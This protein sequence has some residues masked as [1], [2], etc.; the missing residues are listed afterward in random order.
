LTLRLLVAVNA[1]IERAL[2]RLLALLFG[3][4]ILT[5]AWQVV[6]REVLRVPAIWTQ[7]AALFLFA[8]CVFLGSAVAVRRSAHYVC[9]VLPPSMPRGRACL[10]L[11][12]DAGI[13][14]AASVLLWGGWGFAEIGLFRDLETLG[15]AEAWQMAAMPVGAALMLLFLIEV[16]GRDIAALRAAFAA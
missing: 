11:L 8:W 7:E 14:V 6:G 9:E 3:A 16:V 15:I 2:L 10:K 5:I 4:L 1:W 13:A 12:G